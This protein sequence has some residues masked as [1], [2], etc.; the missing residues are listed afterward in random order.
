MN[1]VFKKI[2]AEFDERI[3]ANTQL[4]IR[5]ELGDKI[6]GYA[7][8]KSIEAYKEGRTIVKQVAKEFNNGWIPC[9]KRLPKEPTAHGL[10]DMDSYPEYIVTIEGATKSTFLKYVGNGEW[11]SEGIYYSVVAWQPLPEAY[12]G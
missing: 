5:A 1:K 12:K 8:A 6:C 4:K 10:A 7:Y 2:I 11:Y 9:N 3:N